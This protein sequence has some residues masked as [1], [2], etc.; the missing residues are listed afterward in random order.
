MQ[1]V[2]HDDTL[3]APQQLLF[4]T[5][6]E[7]TSDLSI[8]SNTHGT[9][10]EFISQPH[11][12]TDSDDDMGHEMVQTTPISLS[13]FKQYRFVPST[14]APFLARK[15]RR[16]RHS[17]I[18]ETPCKVGLSFPVTIE[19]SLLPGT[20]PLPRAIGS[21]PSR[22]SIKETGYTGRIQCWLFFRVG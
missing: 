7:G 3:K 5:P 13:N 10:G 4:L 8:K 6:Q 22:P 18:A 9:A 1:Q 15:R 20:M 17:P 2:E 21:W 12:V 11:M 16:S 14:P 19:Y